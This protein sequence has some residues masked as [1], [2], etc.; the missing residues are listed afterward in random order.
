MVYTGVFEYVFEK[1]RKNLKPKLYYLTL[2]SLVFGRQKKGNQLKSTNR[3]NS[4]K[5]LR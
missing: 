5:N 3:N 1:L 4:S 2:I